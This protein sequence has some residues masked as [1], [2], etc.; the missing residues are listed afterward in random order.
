MEQQEKD[1]LKKEIEKLVYEAG[2]ALERYMEMLKHTDSLLK[3]YYRIHQRIRKLRK[4][5]GE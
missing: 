3:E 4:E 2:V 1:E 5:L